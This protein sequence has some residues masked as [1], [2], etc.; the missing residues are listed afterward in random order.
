MQATVSFNLEEFEMNSYANLVRINVVW[1][2]FGSLDSAFAVMGLGLG[3][4]DFFCSL[5]G[6]N[7][8]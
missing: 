4:N 7:E 2:R 6:E 1:L 3:F 5:T 8:Y